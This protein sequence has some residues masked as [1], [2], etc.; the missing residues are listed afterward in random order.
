MKKST[1]LIIF[2]V[3]SGI[4]SQSPQSHIDL[5][6]KNLDQNLKFTA[7]FHALMSLSETIKNVKNN[8]ELIQ[9]AF[10]ILNEIN[11]NFRPNKE[12]MATHADSLKSS[13]LKLLKDNILPKILNGVFFEDDYFNF[14]ETYLSRLYY[15]DDNQTVI[16]MHEQVSDI[17]WKSKNKLK[18]EHLNHLNYVIKA[19][20]SKNEVQKNIDLL[21]LM[22]EIYENNGRTR[23]DN[24][25][26]VYLEVGDQYDEID[27]NSSLTFYDI[28]L[29][30]YQKLGE[31][32]DENILNEILESQ[33]IA[34][35]FSGKYKEALEIEL[36]NLK[37]LQPNNYKYLK[38]KLRILDLY[39]KTDDLNSIQKQIDEIRILIEKI[40][41]Q[42]DSYLINKVELSYIL[43][44]NKDYKN[45]IKDLEELIVFLEKFRNDDFSTTNEIKFL[46]CK[47]LFY[48]N[49]INNAKKIADTINE[50]YLTDENF[51]EFDALKK[52]IDSNHFFLDSYFGSY[53]ILKLILVLIFL[54]SL[55][56]ILKIRK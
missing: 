36:E 22:Q 25:I 16:E 10:E 45:A 26:S 20:V 6:Q 42:K 53:S 13:N 4:Y 29:K 40:D 43:V 23:E 8:K 24:F 15:D 19:Y 54:F 1:L 39:Y 56:F 3:F 49:Q 9:K 55:I 7:E 17:L 12:E 27:I 47:C 46:L 21:A 32:K 33:S 18:I 34:Q 2:F 48:D 51:K 50:K 35:L 41:K 52:N 11:S 37:S 14:Y 38:A 44:E 28:A 31:S 5:A 30:R